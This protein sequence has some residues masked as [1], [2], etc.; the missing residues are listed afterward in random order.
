MLALLGLSGFVG[1][2]TKI[3]GAIIEIATPI[4][5]AVVDGIIWVWQN[6]FWPGLKNI[7]NS[8]ATV[9]TVGTM[10]AC[11]FL[12]I[13][14]NDTIRYNNQARQLNA[15]HVELKK[16][17]RKAPQTDQSPLWEFKWPF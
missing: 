4:L 10:M 12:V 16:L 2:A 11:M 8:W 17:R 6:I 1:L 7:L 14:E 13:H 15:C 5:K 3:L 9:L